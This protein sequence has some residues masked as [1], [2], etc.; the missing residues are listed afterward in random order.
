M[1]HNYKT[2][3][4]KLRE[5]I[6]KAFDGKCFYTSQEVRKEDMVIDHV[7]PKSKGGEDSIYNYVLTTSG[8]NSKKSG[9]IDN[10]GVEPILYLIKLV[11]APKVLRI[12]K[13]LS[14]EDPKTRVDKKR[15]TIYVERDVWKEIRMAATSEGMSAGDYL[16]SLHKAE[17]LKSD[18]ELEKIRWMA[19]ASKIPKNQTQGFM[20]TVKDKPE[21]TKEVTPMGNLYKGTKPKVPNLS[22]KETTEKCTG[23]PKAAIKTVDDI[24][25]WAGGYSKSQQTGKKEGKR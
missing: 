22:K 17:V 7:V 24:P 5:A 14:Q 25:V 4:Y 8:V 13:K 21:P 1:N 19:P 6:Y 3:D 11:Y 16:V 18:M 2:D 12:I 10:D 20:N 23:K 15:S 9:K